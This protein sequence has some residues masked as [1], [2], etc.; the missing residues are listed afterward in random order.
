AAGASGAA[1]IVAV[2]PGA[3]GPGEAAPSTAAGACTNDESPAST[4][5]VASAPPLPFAI[6]VRP[7]PAAPASG[8]KTAIGAVVAD[9]GKGPPSSASSCSGPPSSRAGSSSVASAASSFFP[10]NRAAP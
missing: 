6:A 5:A 1:A 8:A 2:P 9:G 4:A 3:N 7:D 10:D